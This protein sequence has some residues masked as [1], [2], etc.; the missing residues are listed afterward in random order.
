MQRIIELARQRGI[1]ELWG[2]VLAENTPMLELCRE[3]GFRPQRDPDDATLVRVRLDLLEGKR[4]KAGE[5]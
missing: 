3:L 2:D 4:R 1:G 5:R